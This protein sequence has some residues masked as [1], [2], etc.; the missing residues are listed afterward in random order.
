M[1]R[2]ENGE[3]EYSWQL[4][5]V[6]IFTYNRRFGSSISLST[7]SVVLIQEREIIDRIDLCNDESIS[8]E[9]SR[10]LSEETEVDKTQSTEQVWQ[11]YSASPAVK[12]L[13]PQSGQTST[14]QKLSI[15]ADVGTDEITS[16]TTKSAQIISDLSVTND[17]RPPLQ[18]TYV[19]TR[20]QRLLPGE[21]LTYSPIQKKQIAMDMNSIDE[22]KQ[23]ELMSDSFNKMSTSQSEI[24]NFEEYNKSET[25]ESYRSS[26]H[27]R[28]ANDSSSL[29]DEPNGNHRIEVVADIH[30]VNASTDAIS[31]SSAS[32]DR[33]TTSTKL[34]TV[35]APILNT[36]E[37]KNSCK[38]RVGFNTSNSIHELSGISQNDGKIERI[39]IKGGK[40]RRTIF[41]LRKNKI[42]QCK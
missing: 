6:A 39:V 32:S 2:I 11:S 16:N 37:P 29:L 3:Y 28:T 24:Q 18:P 10:K 9:N 14:P 15:M 41:E 1:C 34:S 27:M 19:A 25:F 4:L 12:F 35:S 30:W 42:T 36:I 8:S 5:N 23:S 17:F 7:S 21:Y 31:V 13:R 38:T 33:T 20:R 22:S 40:W 26:V